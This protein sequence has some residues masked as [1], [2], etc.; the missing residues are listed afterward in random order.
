MRV[1]SAA[2]TTVGGKL[3]THQNDEVRR[4]WERDD[5]ESMYD[6]HLL[7]AEIDPPTPRRQ[8]LSNAP[9]KSQVFHQAIPSTATCGGC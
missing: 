9:Y 6:K 5:V 7:A 2:L 1:A 3:M 8:A 4:Y